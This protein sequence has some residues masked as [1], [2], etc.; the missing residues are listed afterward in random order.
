MAELL[1]IVMIV[2]FGLSWPMNLTK[3]IRSR[4]TKGMSLP[5]YCLIFF[6][7]VAGIVSKFVNE[8]YMAQFSDK[9]YVLIFYFLNLFMV[10]AI[11]VVY[12]RNKKLDAANEGSYEK[13]NAFRPAY[14]AAQRGTASVRM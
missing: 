11:I 2:S 8:T 12:F 10:G 6:G 3:A 5:F 7:Y 4:T 9:W 1:E 13:Q 14:G